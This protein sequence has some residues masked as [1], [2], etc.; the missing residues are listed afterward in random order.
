[1]L[2]TFDFLDFDSLGAAGV[3]G[4]RFVGLICC[5]LMV[6][7]EDDA[8]DSRTE[9]RGLRVSSF[10]VTPTTPEVGRGRSGLLAA[11]LASIAADATTPLE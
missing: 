9:G 6:E 3:C 2:S 7:L 8:G 5:D 4:V 1:V 11:Y 10:V